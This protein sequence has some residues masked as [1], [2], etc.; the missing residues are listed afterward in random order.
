MNTE[1]MK[2]LTRLE[3]DFIDAVKTNEQGGSIL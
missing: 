3:D 2:N 1:V